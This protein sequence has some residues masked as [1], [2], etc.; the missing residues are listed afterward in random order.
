MPLW[1]LSPSAVNRA[2]L[3]VQSLK[4]EILIGMELHIGNSFVTQMFLNPNS[5]GDV[6][7]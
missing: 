3:T 7:I 6:F 2:R 5:K 4:F 1:R